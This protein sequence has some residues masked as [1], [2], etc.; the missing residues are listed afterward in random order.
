MLHNSRSGTHALEEI[1][2]VIGVIPRAASYIMIAVAGVTMISG[3]LII[4]LERTNMIGV[5]K[6]LGANNT[7]IRH[8]F[9]WFATFMIGR[10]LIYGNIL[11][12]GI[13][14]LQKY[15]GIFK[16]D[17]TI[18]YVSTVPVEFNFP[19]IL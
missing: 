16:L 17:P 3:L 11:G 18:Y 15:T 9:L 4:I 19:L 14:A 1:P 10:G 8:T 5:L 6:A 12:V 2:S 13:I 7:T